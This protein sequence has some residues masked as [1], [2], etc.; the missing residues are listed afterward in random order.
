MN[1]FVY[2]Q[3]QYQI[4]HQIGSGTYSDVY[5]ARYILNNKLVCIKMVNLDLLP[6]GIE[7]FRKEVSLWSTLENSNML[8]YYGSFVVDSSLWILT[9]YMDGGSLQDIIQYNNKNGIKDEVLLASILEQILLFLKY[10]HSKKLIHRDIRTDNI[11]ITS[12]GVIKV[13]NLSLATCLIQ[14]GQRKRA[15]FTKLKS[16]CY[17]APEVLN[18]SDEGHTESVDIWGI[19]VTAIELSVGEPPYYGLPIMQQ[20]K[21]IVEGKP[22]VLPDNL[23]SS[24]ID[25]ISLCTQHD[26][27]KRPNVETLIHHRLIKM[28]KGIDYIAN[29]LMSQLLPLDRRFRILNNNSEKSSCLSS[30]SCNN[31]ISYDFPD[32]KKKKSD[33]SESQILIK[34]G[35]FTVLKTKKQ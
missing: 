30:R 20:V 23:P 4:L 3:S 10:F 14:E 35:R 13:G 6:D 31:K 29:T 19:G 12:E 21:A 24:V 22:M 32:E 7:M 26:P 28:S 9:E 16:T 11:F 25:F 27:K 15:R 5:V 34:Y 8:P 18:N 2:D 33:D 17:S 1:H